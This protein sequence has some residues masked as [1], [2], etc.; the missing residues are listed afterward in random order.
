MKNRGHTPGSQRGSS[1][2]ATDPAWHTAP[3]GQGVHRA[4]PHRRAL[5]RPKEQEAWLWPQANAMGHWGE[6]VV[7]GGGLELQKALGSPHGPQAE[8]LN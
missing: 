5:P 3:P 6:Y 8:E 7:G 4:E 1:A 2:R